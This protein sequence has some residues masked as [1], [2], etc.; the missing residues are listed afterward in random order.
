M[1][2]TLK[3]TLVVLIVAAGGYWIGLF[4]SPSEYKV[5]SME[6]YK[7]VFL[8]RRGG[9][10]QIPDAMEEA[11][12]A[13][14]L[15]A[16]IHDAQNV[17]LTR[18]GVGVFFD[19]PHEVEL[20]QCRWLIGFAVPLNARKVTADALNGVHSDVRLIE[21]PV[22]VVLET[23]LPWRHAMSPMLGALK[24]WHKLYAHIEERSDLIAGPAVEFYEV[25]EYDSYQLLRYAVYQDQAINDLLQ[26]T[27]N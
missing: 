15:V 19:D 7:F 13:I 22:S 10:D 8:P 2:R 26:W 11:A 6:G 25:D 27:Y 21:V 5:S 1:N 3:L 23:S 18:R 17:T 20:E 12:T 16:Q 9:F 24:V 4:D 14:R